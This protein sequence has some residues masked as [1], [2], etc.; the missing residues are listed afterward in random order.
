M[1]LEKILFI[2]SSTLDKKSLLLTLIVCV[3]PALI[4]GWLFFHSFE[5]SNTFLTV[6]RGCMTTLFLGMFILGVICT[7]HKYILTNSCLIIKHIVIPLTTIKSI[8]LMTSDDKKG[9]W[10]PFGAAGVFGW[11]GYYCTSAHKKLTVFARRYDN[12]TLVVTDSKK[13][14]IAPNDLQLID[15]T[16]QQIGQAETLTPE[17]P[18]KQWRGLALAI[19]IVA[20]MA[21]LYLGYMEP[22]VEFD[23]NAFKLKGLYGV[24]IPFK[25]I[26][27]AD[28]ISWREMPA[29]SLRI[30]GI[31]LFKV[32]RGHFKTRDGDK[33]RLSVHCGVNPVIRIVKKDGSTYYI[34][35][36]N[37]EETRQIYNQ[38]KHSS[39]KTFYLS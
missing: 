39:I 18:R 10:R 7:P 34:N 13:Y 1:N 36:K 6:S 37:P 2:S 16:A 19:I 20:T 30:N 29:I 32:N 15:L 9:L 23:I 33:V 28:T 31:S 11:W 26:E 21:F 27:K 8:H 17:T 4:F 12:W 3:L 24:S 35:R 22:K 38:S 25:E 14:M 5:T